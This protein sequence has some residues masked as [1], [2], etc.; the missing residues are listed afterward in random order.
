MSTSWIGTGETDLH[1]LDAFLMSA[2]A[3]ST[4]MQLS[5]LDG[6]LAG[7]SVGPELIKP[8]EW[9]PLVWGLADPDY[10]DVEEMQSVLG[11]ITGRYNDILNLLENAPRRYEPIFWETDDGVR[12][13][14]DWAEGFMEAVKLRAQAW[15]P[16]FE[17]E[18]NWSLITPIVVQLD[19]EEGEAL[20]KGDAEKVAQTRADATHM[21]ADAVVA[22]DR[23]W[24]ARNGRA[25]KTDK[26]RR[27]DP[28]PCGSGKKYKKCCGA[29]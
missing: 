1:A 17:S 5:E 16:L 27:N 6:F 4:S 24:K 21:I 12:S 19:G 23:Y 11:A 13:S 29:L 10:A 8:A 9:M 22:I 26:I 15:A 28:C 18:T 14:R 7:I 20:V 25:A 2:R 3:P